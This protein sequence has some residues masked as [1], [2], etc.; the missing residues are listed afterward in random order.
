M[1][2]RIV[3][4]EHE[5]TKSWQINGN[6]KYV[7]IIK[8]KFK[9]D[10]ECFMRAK[11]LLQWKFQMCNVPTSTSLSKPTWNEIGCYASSYSD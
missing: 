6:K 10:D 7:L 2:N 9:F 5:Q 8:L 4:Q 11:I 3:F 1:S